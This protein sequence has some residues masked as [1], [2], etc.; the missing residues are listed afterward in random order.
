M[1]VSW[2]VRI[3]V[4]SCTNRVPPLAPLSYRVCALCWQRSRQTPRE[5]WQASTTSSS[6]GCF[7]CSA[8]GFDRLSVEWYVPQ[9]LARVA[10]CNH[11]PPPH[12]V[13]CAVREHGNERPGGV[14][15]D[16]HPSA[17]GANGE[18]NR[19]KG[20]CPGGALTVG[21]GC[22]TNRSELVQD[23]SAVLEKLLV[24]SSIG[25][26]GAIGTSI[27][28]TSGA[29]LAIE[30]RDE[31]VKYMHKE[32]F[33]GKTMYYMNALDRR[34][35]NTDQRMTQDADNFVTTAGQLLFGSFSSSVSLTYVLTSLGFALYKTAG[36]VNG[37]SV[38]YLSVYV[39]FLRIRDVLV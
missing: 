21:G 15:S 18:G 10:R 13:A 1:T 20:W 26:V 33:Q 2:A 22:A 29:R 17:G 25:M 16:L 11:S 9:G 3:H 31:L 37:E 14:A 28:Q 39:G 19:R 38:M 12:A 7:G 6:D 8:L 32:Y 4:D 30:W 5:S 35:D 27:I 24:I 23:M 34:V 36:A